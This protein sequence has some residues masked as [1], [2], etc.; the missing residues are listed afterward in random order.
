[1]RMADR[2]PGAK[3]AP[4]KDAKTGSGDAVK[5]ARARSEVKNGC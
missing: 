5:K 1:M 3:P 2:K 4:E